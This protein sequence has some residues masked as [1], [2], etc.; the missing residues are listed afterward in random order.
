MKNYDV[1]RVSTVPSINGQWNEDGWEKANVVDVDVFRPESSDHRPEVKAKLLYGD[2]GI[3]GLFSVRDQYVR[4]VNTTYQSSVCKDSC[5]EFFF[6]PH[7]GKGY[8][9]L[10]CNCGGS[11]LCYYIEDH[12][13][14]S[15]GLEKM[16]KLTVDD[17][18]GI[19]IYHSM[20]ELVEPEIKEKTDWTVGFFFSFSLIEK[21]SGPLGDLKGKE[22][23]ANFY[24]CGDNTSHPH[25]ASWSPVSTLNF[26]LPDCFGAIHF[27]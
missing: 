12:R 11:F 21:Y 1:E 23:H 2:K 27:K 22:W 14:T 16:T 18:A 17:A 24:K 9:N 6:K 3:Y 13:R 4:C 25:W 7:T 5:V 15:K 10:E 8:F 20:P 26:H 19:K